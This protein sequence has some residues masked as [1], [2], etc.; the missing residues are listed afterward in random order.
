MN[1]KGYYLYKNIQDI[2]INCD[3]NIEI[4]YYIFKDIFKDIESLY[5]QTIHQELNQNQKEVE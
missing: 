5:F 2:L 1:M 3:L 4:I